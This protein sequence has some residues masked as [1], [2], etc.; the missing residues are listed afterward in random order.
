MR[1]GGYSDLVRAREAAAAPPPPP[2]PE[3][4]PARAAARDGGGRPKAPSRRRVSEL[5]R[6]EGRIATLEEGLR[7]VESEL[8][9]PATAADRGRVTALGDRHRELQTELAW[10]MA[11]WERAAEAAEARR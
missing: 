4:R 9:D 5:A 2:A 10:L 3:R 7:E 1:A 11:E 6:I 8:S